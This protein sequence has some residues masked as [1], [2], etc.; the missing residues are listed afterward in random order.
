MQL[1]NPYFT[2]RLCYAIQEN[3]GPHQIR[4]LSSEEEA[5]ATNCPLGEVCPCQVLASP[6]AEPVLVEEAPKAKRK[7]KVAEAD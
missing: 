7:E 4:I 3:I 1:Y 5:L 6:V 2:S